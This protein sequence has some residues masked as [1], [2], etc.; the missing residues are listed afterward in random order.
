MKDNH[1]FMHWFF[2]GLFF[3][4]IFVVLFYISV[5]RHSMSLESERE[6]PVDVGIEAAYKYGRAV[7][8]LPASER[9]KALK[10]GCYTVCGI[11]P[12]E[13]QRKSCFTRCQLRKF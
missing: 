2:V 13:V 11:Y 1:E 10:T 8:R 5:Q 4:L 6:D 7:S 9:A 3:L 12:S